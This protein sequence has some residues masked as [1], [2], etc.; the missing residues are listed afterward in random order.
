M[1]SGFCQKTLTLSLSLPRGSVIVEL[2]LWV[3]FWSDPVIYGLSEGN[4][5]VSE[6]PPHRPIL[7][8]FGL[9]KRISSSMKQSLAKMFLATAELRLDF[10]EQAMDFISVFFRTSTSARICQIFGRAKSKKHEGAIGKD[11]SQPKGRLSTTLDA[12]IVYHDIMRPFAESVLQEKI[13]KGPSENAQWINDT[14][15]HSDVEAK[16][17]QILIELGNDDKYL[18][19]RSAWFHFFLTK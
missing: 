10:P 12:R 19:S 3:L 8:D 18:E 9:T 4:F 2:E 11:E 13:A 15:V 17:R 16:L 14:P 7:L 6:E 1:C 5:L